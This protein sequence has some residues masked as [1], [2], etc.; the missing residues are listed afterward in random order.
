MLFLG[1]F[2][3]FN[4]FLDSPERFI[5]R[6]R[7]VTERESNRNG[8]IHALSQAK[9][10]PTKFQ[11]LIARRDLRRLFNMGIQIPNISD[12]ESLMKQ[13]HLCAKCGHSLMMH[14]GGACTAC[15]TCTV[16]VPRLSSREER[17]KPTV[18]PTEK[19]D[20]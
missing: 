9:L 11:R 12:V 17:D 5:K 8:L 20:E 19:R 16:F 18:I 6:M 4:S 15:L 2:M 3:G 7:L 13:T 1:H 14:T 10:L